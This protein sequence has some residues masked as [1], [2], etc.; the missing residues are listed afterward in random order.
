MIVRDEVVQTRTHQW[1]MVL[2]GGDNR[3]TCATVQR[4]FGYPPPKQYCTFVGTRSM[5]QHTLDRAG[6]IVLL[7]HIVTIIGKDHRPY[8]EHSLA[9][10]LPGRFVEQAANRGTAPAIFLTATYVLAADPE[11]VFL[12]LPSDHFVYPEEK[13][14]LQLSRMADLAQRFRDR[15]ILLGAMPDEPEKD[16]GWIQTSDVM[17]DEEQR[18]FN[19]VSFHEKPSVAEAEAF[20]KDGYLWNTMVMAVNGKNLWD[21]G[22]RFFP[23]IIERMAPL[24][25]VLENVY[26]GA[27]SDPGQIEQIASFSQVYRELETESFS[28]GLLEGAASQMMVMPLR[29]V[30]WSDWGKPV[31]IMNSLKRIGKKPS[32]PI[33]IQPAEAY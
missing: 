16:Y 26:T 8:L 20:L 12:I 22:Q 9:D 24:R 15:I 23:Q 2:A 29:D 1:A 27:A 18:L 14:V 30:Y 25:R 5:L 28:A 17:P 4:W 33:K 19:V 21:L 6:Q 31:R 7:D 32:F 13:F 10:E 11:A 3:G